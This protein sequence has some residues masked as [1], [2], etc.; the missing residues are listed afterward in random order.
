MYNK[1]SQGRIEPNRLLRPGHISCVCSKFSS[2][3]V[4]HRLR[5]AVSDALR[6]EQELSWSTHDVCMGL[7]VVLAG[8]FLHFIRIGPQ[9]T[10]YQ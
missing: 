4:V 7:S 1:C 2:F 9:L 6:R 10:S 8:I 3:Y 5:C